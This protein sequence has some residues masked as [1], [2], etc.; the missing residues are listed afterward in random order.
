MRRQERSGMIP[1]D[2]MHKHCAGHAARSSA[3][4]PHQSSWHPNQADAYQRVQHPNSCLAAVQVPP[5]HH[6]LASASKVDS[7]TPA[8]ATLP[9]AAPPASGASGGSPSKARTPSPAPVALGPALP[10]DSQTQQQQQ[11]QQQVG[12]IAGEGGGGAGHYVLRPPVRDVGGPGGQC[13]GSDSSIIGATVGP[14]SASRP[15]SGT[16]AGVFGLV[17]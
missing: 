5:S 1:L 15:V 10:I 11:Q 9:H 4:L 8:S 13:G 6:R 16:D 7:A 2:E 12:Q 3:G 14:A 17:L